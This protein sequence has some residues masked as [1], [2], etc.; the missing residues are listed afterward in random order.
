MPMENMV[1]MF[2][3]GKKKSTLVDEALIWWVWL[4]QVPPR[5][6]CRASPEDLDGVLQHGEFD[7]SQGRSE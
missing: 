3:G 4:K 5:R 1:H 6:R 2:G 7:V